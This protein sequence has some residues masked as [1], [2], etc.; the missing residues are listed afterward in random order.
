M[1]DNYIQ[2]HNKFTQLVQI[3]SKLFKHTNFFTQAFQHAQDFTR[4]LQSVS[5]LL[6]QF[7]SNLQNIE[8]FNTNEALSFFV[9]SKKDV[10][11]YR[12]TRT[13]KQSKII[14]SLVS[15]FAFA[16]KHSH[17]NPVK[18][19]LISVNNKKEHTI[20]HEFVALPN[21]P[22][23]LLRGTPLLLIKTP[24]NEI[25]CKY[26][27]MVTNEEVFISTEIYTGHLSTNIRTYLG[28]NNQLCSLGNNKYLFYS[29][30]DIDVIYLSSSITTFNNSGYFSVREIL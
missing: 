24:M 8:L 2:L 10:Y 29:Q 14:N 17:I 4:L 1:T 28:K 15:D 12:Q 11:L 6:Q 30:L 7:Q 13:P 5:Q 27:D 3:C 20:I 22:Q 16:L 25:F 19:S 9:K 26:T 21:K 18:C 23:W